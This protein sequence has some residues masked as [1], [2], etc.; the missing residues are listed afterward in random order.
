MHQRFY[1]MTDD[2]IIEYITAHDYHLYYTRV[3]NV[4][5]YIQSTHWLVP[6]YYLGQ[7]SCTERS[8]VTTATEPKKR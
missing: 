8:I 3:H 4:C 6:G 5:E 7:I 2:V 1:F